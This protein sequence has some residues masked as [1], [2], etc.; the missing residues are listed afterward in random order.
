MAESVRES[1]IEVPLL[2]LLLLIAGGGAVDL[3][4]DAPSNWLSPHVLYELFLIAAALG[5][6][7]WLWRRWRAAERDNA[8]LEGLVTERQA[9]RDAWRASAEQALVGLAVAIDRQLAAWQLTPAEREVAILLLKG[10]SHKEIAAASGRSERTVRQHAVAAYDKAGV[11]GR[12][13]LAAFFL[14]DLP[15]AVNDPHAGR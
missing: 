13:E 2:A 11:A 8:R 3:A 7:A 10:K 15:L 5:S 4:L 1:A 6:A 9:E 14:T 12:A